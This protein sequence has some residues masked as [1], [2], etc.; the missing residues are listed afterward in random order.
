M[1]TVLKL[2]SLFSCFQ[3]IEA[4]SCLSECTV[5]VLKPSYKKA[6]D[7]RGVVLDHINVS[8]CLPDE[9]VWSLDLSAKTLTEFYGR[10]ISRTFPQLNSLD[11]EKNYFE[12]L[13]NE[14]F[15]SM[16]SLE[17]IRVCGNKINKINKGTFED[18][19]KLQILD[20]SHNELE[21]LISDWFKPMVELRELN[22]NNNKIKDF[23]PDTFYWTPAL[24]RLTL[25]YNLI[26]IIPPLNEDDQFSM[27]LEGNPLFCGCKRHNHRNV[28]KV[29]IQGGCHTFKQ[30]L[31]ILPICCVPEIKGRIRFLE[32]S[33]FIQCQWTGNPNPEVYLMFEDKVLAQNHFDNKI[34]YGPVEEGGIYICKAENVM[35]VAFINITVEQNLATASPFTCL[36][37]TPENLMKHTSTNVMS[38]SVILIVVVGISAGASLLS[39]VTYLILSFL[40]LKGQVNEENEGQL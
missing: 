37:S 34:S 16:K 27:D 1:V 10:I 8:G 31:Q 25:R 14:T 4:I 7:C 23:V 24:V 33:Y 35:G 17:I 22:L 40:F 30:M 32:K 3:Q 21:I 26:T 13:T 28:M 12:G 6:V 29:T 5:K 20:L 11:L 2:I 19:T 15:R 9:R 36:E 38:G 18:Q 39:T